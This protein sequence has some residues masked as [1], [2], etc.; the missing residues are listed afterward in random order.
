MIES[1][2]LASLVC[3]RHG[4][5]TRDTGSVGPADSARALDA[6]RQA[7]RVLGGDPANLVNAHQVHGARVAL[8][9]SPNWGQQGAIP[10]TDGLVTTEPG[11]ALMVQGADC[12]LLL[13]VD[14]SVPALALVHS[15]W[16]GTVAGIGKRAVEV[17]TGAGA[18]PERIRAAVFPGI[19]ACCF[20]VG[21]DVVA[22]F[23]AAF[24]P[25]ARAWHAPSGPASGP[26]SGRVM[27]DLHAAI[28]A[29]LVDAGLRPTAVDLVAG[30]TACDGTLW[31]HRASGGGPERHGLFA[32]LL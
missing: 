11:T 16:R 10:A 28:A 8:V 30:C 2:G 3:V 15:G 27:L 22:A 13:L 20:E 7:V 14:A 18:R 31:S 23:D 32:L 4:L 1:P 12:P 5:T 29:T 25:R 9:G 26:A 21:G 17:M 6:R 19:S 24:G